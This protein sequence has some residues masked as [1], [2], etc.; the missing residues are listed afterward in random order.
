MLDFVILALFS[1][2]ILIFWGDIAALASDETPLVGWFRGMQV[3]GKDRD[4]KTKGINLDKYFR[5][6]D[7]DRRFMDV[8]KNLKA[9][10][11]LS[12]PSEQTKGISGKGKTHYKFRFKWM[13][14]LYQKSKDM[15]SAVEVTDSACET[16]TDAISWTV[17]KPTTKL[18]LI[19]TSRK[20][21]HSWSPTAVVATR[22]TL[23][24]EWS[25]GE[26]YWWTTSKWPN[27]IASLDIPMDLLQSANMPTTG[28]KI[29]SVG[30]WTLHR[31]KLTA[32]LANL[33]MNCD[34]TAEIMCNKDVE[35]I[36]WAAEAVGGTNADRIFIDKQTWWWNKEVQLVITEKKLALNT[37][38]FS[39]NL[40]WYWSLNWKEKGRWQPQRPSCPVGHVTIQ[41]K[42]PAM[43]CKSAEQDHA[44]SISY[45]VTMIRLFVLH[46]QWRIL[47]AASTELSVHALDPLFSPRTAQEATWL[48]GKATICFVLCCIMFRGVEISPK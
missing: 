4:T 30:K 33:V 41:P 9:L 29:F 27:M 20:D 11:C 21:Q 14:T 2:W 12:T 42:T 24:T 37:I 5:S 32:A 45:P 25:R 1:F 48:T 28:P 35:Q 19:C 31:N 17:V 43:S 23:T 10:K 44:G 40:E 18:W 47:A 36:L 13:D 6:G 16:T 34:Q 7:K 15:H 8:D 39:V 3:N 22:L 46:L 26:T 38:Q